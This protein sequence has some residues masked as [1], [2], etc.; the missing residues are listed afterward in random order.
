MAPAS[1][2]PRRATFAFGW[3]APR[4][5]YPLIGA[6]SFL[7]LSSLR[8]TVLPGPR[9]A[10]PH[11]PKQA[12]AHLPRSAR[13]GG[14]PRSMF[15]PSISTARCFTFEDGVQ[16]GRRSGLYAGLCTPGYDG[17][18][19]DLCSAY[20]SHLSDARSSNGWIH[21]RLSQ[22]RGSHA[23]RE[24]RRRRS[25]CDG[26][27]QDRSDRHGAGSPDWPAHGTRDVRGGANDRCRRT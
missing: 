25:T 24:N 12:S 20:A 18:Q 3:R 5:L 8:R 15:S 21:A 11:R 14:S 27:R 1:S 9:E 10:L 23:C 4:G 6:G 22:A 17:Q 13:A 16:G 2:A 7:R 26:G 19:M